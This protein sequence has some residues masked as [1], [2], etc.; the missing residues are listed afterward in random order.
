MKKNSV[1]I[2]ILA[3]I[4]FSCNNSSLDKHKTKKSDVEIGYD[5]ADLTLEFDAEKI[6]LLSIMKDVSHEK[7]HSILR[8]YLVVRH[9]SYLN[10][11]QNPNY[12]IDA[13]DSISQKNELALN[14]TA[15]I[16]YNYKYGMISDD[17]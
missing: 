2:L 14:V 8:D 6:G 5:I 13:V 10:I 4:S 3:I 9:V 12:I 16:I 17:Y 7:V 1:F 11:T 15:S